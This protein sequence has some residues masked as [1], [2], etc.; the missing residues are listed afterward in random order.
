ML[1][2]TQAQQIGPRVVTNDVQVTLR[3]QLVVEIN[4]GVK[5][6]FLAWVWG[7]DQRLASWAVDHGESSAWALDEIP[8]LDPVLLL[9]LLGHDLRCKDHKGA[10]LHSHYLSKH[11]AHV[12]RDMILQ[13]AVIIPDERPAGHVNV[14]ILRV[15]V[16][17]QKGLCVFPAV[18]TSDISVGG[19]HDSLQGLAL[20]IAPVCTFDV[21][22]LDLSTMVHDVAIFVDERL[23]RLVALWRR[24]KTESSNLCDV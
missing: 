19:W 17:T 8:I 2:D 21:G 13:S 18:E 7:F 6:N 1:V 22:G 4:V 3:L 9:A 15:L 23:G 12:R 11:S 10:T 16:V 20:S 5:D 24:R 14:D